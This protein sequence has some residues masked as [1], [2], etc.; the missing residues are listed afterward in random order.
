MA[1]NQVS[2]V[3]A[4]VL[5]VISDVVLTYTRT[6]SNREPIPFSKARALRY[7][8]SKVGNNQMHIR[9]EITSEKLTLS[10]V[11]RSR[12]EFFWWF[13]ADIW[14]IRVHF[15]RGPPTIFRK[16]MSWGIGRESLGMIRCIFAENGPLEGGIESSFSDTGWGAKGDF[17]WIFYPNTCIFE[18]PPPP[19]PPISESTCPQ[20]W[21]HKVWGWSDVYSRRMGS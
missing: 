10:G 2:A 17:R 5:R 19:H 9:G 8:H 14:P 13:E 4:G 12:P 3:P 6:F 20:V 16:H 7:T 18:G 1:L 15:R 11:V 21:A